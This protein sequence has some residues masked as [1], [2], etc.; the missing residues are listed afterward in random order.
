MRSLQFLGGNYGQ[1]VERADSKKLFWQLTFKICVKR[2][3]KIAVNLA[4]CLR[5][6]SSFYRI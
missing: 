4:F 5:R 1:F 3:G 6:E 2:N